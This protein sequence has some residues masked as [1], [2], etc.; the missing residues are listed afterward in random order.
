MLAEGGMTCTALSGNSFALYSKKTVYQGVENAGARE[1]M[2]RSALSLSKPEIKL[3]STNIEPN[4]CVVH[5]L[6]Y[7]HKFEDLDKSFR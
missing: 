6:P 3:A 1:V 7:G 5:S 2:L 4:N